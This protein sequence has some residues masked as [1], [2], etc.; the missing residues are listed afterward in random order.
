VAGLAE[1]ARQLPAGCPI[2]TTQKDLVKLR[3]SHLA[4]K[5]LWALRIRLHVETGKDDLDRKLLHVVGDET[6]AV[7]ENRV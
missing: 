2:A 7:L 4:D 3:F 1:W 6:A 5:P